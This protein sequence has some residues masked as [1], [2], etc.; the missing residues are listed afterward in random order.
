MGD[1]GVLKNGLGY[2][3]L[4]GLNGML[5]R[6]ECERVSQS[7]NKILTFNILT[8]LENCFYVF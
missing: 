4:H 1:E 7:E 3:K 8:V 6:N 2:V 5:G